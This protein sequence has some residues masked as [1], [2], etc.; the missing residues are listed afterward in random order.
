ME[1][2]SSDITSGHMAKQLTPEELD[3]MRAQNS[4]LVPENRALLLE[5]DA[6]KYWDLFYKRNDT[7]FFKDR[8]WTTR[9][10]EELANRGG[11]IFE[12]GC[13][14]GNLI[15]PLLEDGL[16]FKRIY[17]C[18]LSPRAIDFVKSH[19]LY[20]ENKIKAFQTDITTDNY[21][22]LLF[23]D[24]GLYDMAQLRFKPGNKIAE[25]FYM[26]QDGTRSYYFS[27]EELQKIFESAGFETITCEYVHRRT[28]NV[29]EKVDVPRIF[30]QAKFRKP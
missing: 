26:R 1:D 17:V 19:S 25:N 27:V 16:N 24:Y 29:K 11:S 7:R 30:V 28:V 14:V 9:E 13:G 10:F 6:K 12:V 22:V 4:R 23:R 8:H 21:G 2:S 3:K 5:K 20:N 18:D 15:Y